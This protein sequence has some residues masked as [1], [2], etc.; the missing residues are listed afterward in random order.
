MATQDLINVQTFRLLQQIS[1]LRVKLDSHKANT[2]SLLA[3]LGHGSDDLAGAVMFDDAAIDAIDDQEA[4]YFNLPKNASPNDLI[5]ALTVW[6][7][8]IW[9][10]AM[11]DS[12]GIKTTAD[13]RGRGVV[14]VS[15]AGMIQEAIDKL[16]L[17]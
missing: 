10:I 8:N 4:R 14:L 11:H 2:L 7:D 9:R 16:D 17:L 12:V 13:T 15:V 6:R 3:A 1:S 5:A